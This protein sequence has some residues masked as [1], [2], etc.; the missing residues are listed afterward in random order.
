MFTGLSRAAVLAICLIPVGARLPAAEGASPD[1]ISRLVGQLGDDEFEKREAASRELEAVGEPALPALR[2]AASGK[3]L[4]ARRRARRV[5]EVLRRRAE[6]QELDRWE[7][8]WRRSDG[9][10]LTLKGDRWAWFAPDRAPA[11][12]SLRIVE[13]G[14]DRSK[15]D[16]IHLTGPVPG[17]TGKA[18]VRRRGDLLYWRATSTPA[19]GYPRD[20]G[21]DDE[22]ARVKKE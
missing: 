18:I 16:F 6:K 20:F 13:L 21:K 4:E 11:S 22:W 8:R 5:I 14:K 9:V 10:E 19:E 17:V 7:G 1:R 15:I 12:G 2:E 3:N